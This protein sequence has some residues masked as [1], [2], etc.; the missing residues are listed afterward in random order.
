MENIPRKMAFLVRELMEEYQKCVVH[1]VSEHVIKDV[2]SRLSMGA[3]ATANA[4]SAE[5]RAAIGQWS[6]SQFPLSYG[7]GFEL[8]S[9]SLASTTMD[10]GKGL[11]FTDPKH[12]SIDEFCH[13]LFNMG[14]PNQPS[15][16]SP[17]LWRPSPLLDN[18]RVTVQMFICFVGKNIPQNRTMSDIFTVYVKFA[19]NKLKINFGPWSAGGF[20]GSGYTRGKTVDR[21]VVP[22]VWC[23]FGKPP[24]PGSEVPREMMDNDAAVGYKLRLA[25][26]KAINLDTRAEWAASQILIGDF[27]IH[28]KRTINPTDLT[29]NAAGIDGSTSS[30][31]REV[32][33]WA[34]M[35][36]DINDPVHH[37]VLFTAMMFQKARPYLN[38]P[39]DAKVGAESFMKKKPS[40]DLEQDDD[41]ETQRLHLCRYICQLPWLDGRSKG[42]I[43]KEGEPFI[44]VF[45]TYFL[46]YY[47]KDQS[48][49]LKSNTTPPGWANKHSKLCLEYSAIQKL[50]VIHFPRTQVFAPNQSNP[51]SSCSCH[52]DWC[53]AIHWT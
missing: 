20:P 19:C 31:I 9:I 50:T 6:K 46:A 40:D 44:P 45:V 18:L 2:K 48:P 47:L 29:L 4:Y 30:K 24:A 35:I 51:Y 39:T 16:L 7:E 36:F 11:P 32:Y 13:L 34:L 28:F 33:E 22:T 12:I 14:K 23:G 27:S 43:I 25:K 49:L 37:L 15:A 21:K 42:N 10:V 5:R 52:T 17:P 26:H 1:L 8:L 3:S 53:R 38:W 41:F